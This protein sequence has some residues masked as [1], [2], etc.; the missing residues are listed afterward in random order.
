MPD[1]APLNYRIRLVPD[2]G[3]FTFE[4][5]V[6][7]RLHLTE[8]ADEVVLNAA[9]L[10][11]WSCEVRRGEALEPCSFRVDPKAEEL[12]VRL[13]AGVSGEVLI[14]MV[15]TGRINDRMAGFYRSQYSRDGRTRYIAVTQFQESDARRAFPCFDHPGRKATFDIEMEVSHELAAIANTDI[16]AQEMLKGGRKR[17][18]FETTPTMSTYLVFFGVGDFEMLQDPVDS[19]VRV[20]TLPGAW[21]H[22]AFGLEFGRKALE[23]SETYYDIPYPLSKLDLIAVPD[24]AFGAMENW[25]GHHLPGKLAAALRRDYVQVRGGTDL[26]GDR[27]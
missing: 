19:R 9:E 25:G 20:L 17:I 3:R 23:F 14:H 22:A 6:D 18:I 11:V 16:K 7:I 15:Y 12:R 4:G 26:R 21:R 2:L 8:P 1:A 10:A 5:Q 24:F 27:P 13:P